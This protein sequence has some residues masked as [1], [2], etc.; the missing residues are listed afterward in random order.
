MHIAESSQL[1]IC[2]ALFGVDALLG[3]PWQLIDPLLIALPISTAVMI[4]GWFICRNQA[5]VPAA[6]NRELSGKE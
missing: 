3:Q 4:I 5:D 1:G 6:T 2:K